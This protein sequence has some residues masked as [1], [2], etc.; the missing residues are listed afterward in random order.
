MEENPFKK[1]AIMKSVK[2]NFDVTKLYFH[3]FKIILEDNQLL[4]LVGKIVF[5]P[6]NSHFHSCSIC[7]GIFCLSNY[8]R[9]LLWWLCLTYTYIHKYIHT[10]M[11]NIIYYKYYIY[12]ILYILYKYYIFIYIYIYMYIT[13]I[14]FSGTVFVFFF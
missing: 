2:T 8:L 5:L 3:K 10:Q 4:K 9:I 1:K 6:T 13:N 11:Y 12:Y 7:K 14:P